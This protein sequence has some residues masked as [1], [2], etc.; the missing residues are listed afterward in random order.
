MK[1]SIWGTRGSQ[2]SPGPDTIRYGGNTSCV[3]LE[4]LPD[5]RLILDAGT[6][7]RVA[8]TRLAPEVRRVDLLL[9]HLH[10]DHI[11]GL[12]FFE[13]LFRPGFEVHIWGPGS[14]TA[15]LRARLTRYISP[16]LFPVR[17]S[18]LP[19]DLHLHDLNHD[20]IDVP[21]FS[22]RAELVCHPGPTVGFRLEDEHGT[23]AYL[24]DHEPMLACSRFAD[25][26]EWCSGFEV[27]SGIDLLLHDAQYSDAEYAERVGW[28][29]STLN[30]ALAFARLAK[31]KRLM[32][33]HH[34]PAHDD[35]T[36][37]AIF[38]DNAAEL[39]AVFPARE[40]TTFDLAELTGA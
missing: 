14:A 9:T 17:L 36:L 19:C 2:A 37:D 21:G 3:E 5:T 26:P 8:G 25:S 4:G 40:G 35:D 24:P 1:V 27:A 11:Q 38:A 32:P 7:L 29:H 6:G 39:F 10:L 12:G 23:L 22:V 18:E 31:V 15:Q 34:D 28:G 30:H 16:P 20:R 13:P 33:F